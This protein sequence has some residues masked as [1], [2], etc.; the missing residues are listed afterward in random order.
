MSVV[1][2]GF[3]VALSGVAVMSGLWL[4]VPSVN[5]AIRSGV[6]HLVGRARARVA[7]VTEAWW[8]RRWRQRNE[9][10]G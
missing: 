10:R 3:G 7:A 5:V 4:N 6:H 1:R 9:Q 8:A 2:Y